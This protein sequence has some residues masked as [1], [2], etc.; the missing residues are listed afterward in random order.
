MQRMPGKIQRDGP[1]RRIDQGAR[2]QSAGVAPHLRIEPHHAQG[3]HQRGR[4]D[5]LGR[6]QLT[7]E[8]RIEAFD[9]GGTAELLDEGDPVVIGIPPY[10]R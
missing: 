8:S 1:I 6:D 3:E 9:P 4:E 10:H 2:G 5:D 7:H